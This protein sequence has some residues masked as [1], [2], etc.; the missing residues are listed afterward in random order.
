[1]F[2]SVEINWR[3]Q[4]KNFQMFLTLIVWVLIEW[5]KRTY[6]LDGNKESVVFRFGGQI[7]CNIDEKFG[8]N[9]SPKEIS[10][11]ANRSVVRT[12]YDTNQNQE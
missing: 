10:L 5:K 6:A 8:L 11:E 3:K 12:K 9:V 1:M 2:L 4:A 7:F